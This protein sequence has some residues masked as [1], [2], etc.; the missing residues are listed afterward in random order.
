MTMY[1]KEVKPSS[2]TGPVQQGGGEGQGGRAEVWVPQPQ[3]RVQNAAGGER[4]RRGYAAGNFDETKHKGMAE[5]I[6]APRFRAGR[7]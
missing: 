4:L 1:F 5:K 2:P 7:T 6:R 3:L